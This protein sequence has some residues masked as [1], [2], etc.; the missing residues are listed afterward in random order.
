MIQK[1]ILDLL[2]GHTNGIAHLLLR[3]VRQAENLNAYNQLSDEELIQLSEDL[4]TI[5]A[6]WYSKEAGKNELGAYF[7]KM[8]RDRAKMKLPVSEVSYIL[9]LARK[10][11]V[12]YLLSET[13]IDNSS[14][15]YATV[16]SVNRISDFFMLASYYI[17]KGYLEA[18]YVALNKKEDISS[19]VLKQ[20]FPDDFFFKEM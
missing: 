9:I 6:R 7:A 1:A 17:I 14:A 20:Y 8:G 4:S 2:T 16:E 15:L 19:S 13:E 3:K 11:I 12:E 10:S 5:L 18:V